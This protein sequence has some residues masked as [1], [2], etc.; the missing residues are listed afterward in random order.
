MTTA[1]QFIGSIRTAHRGKVVCTSN[2]AQHYFW[3]KCSILGY[4][5]GQIPM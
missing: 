1:C 5:V 3:W 4:M 2:V